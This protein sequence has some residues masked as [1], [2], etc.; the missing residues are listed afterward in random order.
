M[1]ALLT[2]VHA[3]TGSWLALVILVVEGVMIVL[4]MAVGF[5]VGLQDS[6]L[7]FQMKKADVKRQYMVLQNLCNRT[8]PKTLFWKK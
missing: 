2:Y 1:T 6:E 5:Q 3:H 7:I 4:W 8:L